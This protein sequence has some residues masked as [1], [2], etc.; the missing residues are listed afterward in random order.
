MLNSD[1]MEAPQDQFS[2]KTTFG[3]AAGPSFGYNFTDGFGFR[4]NFLFSSQ[5][6][7]FKNINTTANAAV[8]NNTHLPAYC[9]R[10]LRQYF[11]RCGT[12]I[13][14]TSAVV[15]NNDRMRSRLLRF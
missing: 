6:Q 14:D 2:Y 13:Q 3:M 7:R 10:Y 4:M 5:G 12:L 15:R 1:D 9:R 11:C 8:N